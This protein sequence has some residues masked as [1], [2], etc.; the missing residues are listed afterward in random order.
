MSAFDLTVVDFEL[1]KVAPRWV[2][3]KI[4]TADGIVGWGGKWQSYVLFP[5]FENNFDFLLE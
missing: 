4:V 2:F 3:L 1:F 5:A